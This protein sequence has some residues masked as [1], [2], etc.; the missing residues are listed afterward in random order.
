MGFFVSVELFSR[1]ILG[2]REIDNR[3]PMNFNAPRAYLEHLVR[4]KNFIKIRR[5][6]LQEKIESIVYFLSIDDS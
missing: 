3:A 5:N 1:N 4:C 6:Q 2:Y